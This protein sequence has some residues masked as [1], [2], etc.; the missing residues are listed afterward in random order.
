[1]KNFS[2]KG[3]FSLLKKT[4]LAGQ[5]FVHETSQVLVKTVV[6]QKILY[7]IEEVEF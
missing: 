5:H 3:L 7:Y 2:V 4:L 1:V 6:V